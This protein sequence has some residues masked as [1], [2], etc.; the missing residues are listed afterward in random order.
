MPEEPT[1]FEQ[2]IQG[3]PWPSSQL[4]KADMI[5]LTELRNRTRRPITKLLHE[6]VAAYHRVLT[7][8]PR[9]EKLCCD[10]PDLRWEGPRENATLVCACC[11]FVLSDD[12]QLADW[13]DP[14]QIA[15]EAELKVEEAALETIVEKP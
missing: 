8:A 1:D 5:R 4:T 3:Y 2:I 10:N 13:H 11:G 7:T 14:E 9:T 12:G 6:A 15:C